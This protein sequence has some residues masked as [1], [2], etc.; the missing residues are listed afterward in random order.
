MKVDS[1]NLIMMGE[2]IHQIWVNNHGDLDCISSEGELATD[3][4]QQTYGRHSGN[5]IYHIQL[6]K[7]SFF[8]RYE[9]K[10]FTE[11]SSDAHQRYCFHSLE[12]GQANSL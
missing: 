11:A 9:G 10:S 7:S 8:S 2:S 3:Q 5:E 12:Y 4:W 6:G 1:P